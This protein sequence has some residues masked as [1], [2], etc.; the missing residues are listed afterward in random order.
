MYEHNACVSNLL[1]ILKVFMSHD[2]L[3]KVFV[4]NKETMFLWQCALSV[5]FSCIWLWRNAQ[6]SECLFD[7]HFFI[8]WDY[9]YHFLFVT[10]YSFVSV[11]VTV[12]VVHLMVIL[13]FI[14]FLCNI[15]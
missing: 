9:I 14:Y 1:H 7:L 3:L 15:F 6:I 13:Y 5:V 11:T 8:G 2:C 4:K 10:C 12:T